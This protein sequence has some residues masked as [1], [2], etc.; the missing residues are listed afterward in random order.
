MQI[1]FKSSSHLIYRRYLY[2]LIG[3]MSFLEVA[4]LSYFAKNF[5]YKVEGKL[6]VWQARGGG[7]RSC[8][9][10]PPII[11]VEGTQDLQMLWSPDASIALH[12][13][14]QAQNG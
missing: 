6:C 13:K 3:W 7:R 5:T 8:N 1:Y 11:Q 2:D 4:A 12:D 14:I 10:L 9:S